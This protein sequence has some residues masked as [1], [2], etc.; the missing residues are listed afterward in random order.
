MG[1]HW[2]NPSDQPNGPLYCVIQNRIV[3]VEYAVSQA[4]LE[5][6]KSFINL[7]WPL[8]GG[9][10]LPRINHVDLNFQP[11]GHPG[12]TEPHYD[13]HIYFITKQH[14]QRLAPANPTAGSSHSHT[15]G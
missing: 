14:L 5:A 7:K 15:G 9:T 10:K 6:G 8:R 3:C 2:A 1:A 11:T 4:D 12:F 13:L